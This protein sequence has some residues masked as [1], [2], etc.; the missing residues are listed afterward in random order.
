MHSV[1]H[2]QLLAVACVALLMKFMRL[3]DE[4][5]LKYNSSRCLLFHYC[6][7]MLG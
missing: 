2:K 5:G 7:L 6:F 4:V 1:G 3:L